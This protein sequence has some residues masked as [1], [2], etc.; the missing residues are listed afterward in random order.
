M[1]ILLLPLLATAALI[2]PASAARERSVRDSAEMRAERDLAKLLAGRTA[3]A[4]QRCRSIQSNESAA[5]HGDALVWQDGRT[6]WVNRIAACPA[7]R[8]DPL[9]VFEN[10]GGQQCRLEF[11]QAVPRGTSVPGRPCQFGAFVPWRKPR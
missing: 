7:L 10:W 2:G 6:I 3:G 5:I 9:L 4:P 1:R 11:F 8:G